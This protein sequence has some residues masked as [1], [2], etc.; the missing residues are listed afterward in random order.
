MEKDL[1]SSILLMYWWELW[2]KQDEEILGEPSETNFGALFFPE[3]TRI[4]GIQ[5]QVS[6]GY[7][8]EVLLAAAQTRNKIKMGPSS[9]RRSS[10]RRWSS[11]LK[12]PSENPFLWS[13]FKLVEIFWFCQSWP[14]SKHIRIANVVKLLKINI[15]FNIPVSKCQVLVLFILENLEVS[16]FPLNES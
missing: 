11:D 8:R 6:S 5:F 10:T 9:I 1:G 13:N 2:W 4:W 3:L 15:Q 14:K 16:I 7:I 12:I